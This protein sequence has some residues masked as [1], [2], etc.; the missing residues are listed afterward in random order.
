MTTA[1]AFVLR[2]DGLV[3]GA[4]VVPWLLATWTRDGVNGVGTAIFWT[5]ARIPGLTAGGLDSCAKLGR[6]TAA[7]A[8]ASA[9][10]HKAGRHVRTRVFTFSSSLA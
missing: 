1:P 5:D 6:G 2:N 3:G 10:T 7:T 9:R 4:V 8:S